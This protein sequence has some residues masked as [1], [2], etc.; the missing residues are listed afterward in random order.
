MTKRFLA[1]SLALILVLLT[2]V[3]AF[4]QTDTTVS[5]TVLSVD[6]AAGTFEMSTAAGDVL[7]V[8]P[9]ASFDLATLT[10]GSPIEV[11]G[12]LDGSA[13]TAFSIFPVVDD[14]LDDKVNK[15]FFCTNAESSQ[16]AL[17]KLAEEYSADYAQLLDWFCSGHYGVGEIMLALRASQS[18]GAASAQELLD[19][20]KELG[21]WGKVWQELGLVGQGHNDNDDQGGDEQEGD[22]EGGDQGASGDDNGHEPNGNA[23]GQS[24]DGNGNSGDHGNG[25]DGEHGNGKGQGGGHGH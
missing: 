15:G 7:T 6:L 12:S 8:T 5:G 11:Q 20:K 1:V 25:N 3:P 10:V 16:P 4:A 13:L 19:M 24:Q 22:D 2:V 23:N 17:T 14:N 21:G 18:G 9:P